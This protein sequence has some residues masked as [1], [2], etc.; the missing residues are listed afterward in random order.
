MAD[1][2]G[3]SRPHLVLATANP[4]KVAELVDLLG[5]RFTVSG[6]PA[7]LPA[8]VEDADTLEGNALKKARE[9]AAAAGQA[10]LSDDTGLFVEALDG[11]PGVHTARYGP[12]ESGPTGGMERL[13]AELDGV[14]DRRAHFR[15]V[16][17]LVGADRSELVAHG[18]VDGTIAHGPSGDE[19]FG[20]DPVFVPDEGDGRTFAEMSRAEKAAISHRSR[21]LLGLLELLA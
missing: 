3:G 8:T 16:V 2:V 9:V 7:D 4:G 1:P 10:A 15:T 17:V 5:D 11:R 20:Y 14:A 21:A 18:R 13:L 6:R 12:P 19:G